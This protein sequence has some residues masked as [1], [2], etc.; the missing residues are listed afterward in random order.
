MGTATQIKSSIITKGPHRAYML[1]LP[2]VRGKDESLQNT[3]SA[4]EEIKNGWVETAMYG[5]WEELMMLPPHVIVF[6]N[7]KPR[8][9]LCSADRW[10]VYQLDSLMGGMKRI[11]LRK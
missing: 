4:I 3:F 1:D 6:S 7:D 2:R 5:K 10:E 9:D 8:L 11:R